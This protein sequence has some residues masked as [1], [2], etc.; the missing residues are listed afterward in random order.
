M[1]SKFRFVF[2]ALTIASGSAH[3]DIIGAGIGGLIGSQFGQGNG[4]IAMAALGAVIGDRVSEG[5]SAR[6]N[7]TYAYDEESYPEARP[8]TYQRAY[9]VPADEPQIVRVTPVTPGRIYQ[10]YPSQAYYGGMYVQPGIVIGA[11]PSYGYRPHPGL[12]RGH[13]GM[14]RPHH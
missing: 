11:Y 5:A 9:V 10:P 3:A 4:K 13:Y 8:R 7:E 1:K 6:G 14:Y 12:H 2:I